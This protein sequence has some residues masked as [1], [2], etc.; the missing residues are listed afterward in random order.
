MATYRI[1]YTDGHT[2]YRDAPDMATARHMA[3]LHAEDARLHTLAQAE[4]R[5]ADCAPRP[6]H[7]KVTDVT[8]E[9]RGHAAYVS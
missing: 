1:T 8:Y 3:S 5:L 2:A 9:P 7:G 4:G 6:Y